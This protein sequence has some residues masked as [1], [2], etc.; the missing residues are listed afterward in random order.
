MAA[1]SIRGLCAALTVIAALGAP[2][3]AALADGVAAFMY[4]RFGEDR[5]PSTSVRLEQFDAHLEWLAREQ[6]Q[7]WPLER[8]VAHLRE[9]KP[10]P[11]R[12][13][14]LTVDDAFESVYREAWPRLKRRGWPMTVFVSTHDVD[15]GL[16]AFMTWDQMRE[17]RDGG[18]TFA[19]H[20]LQHHSLVERLP[21][22][23]QAEW[24]GRI[25]GEIMQA[26]ARLN[27]ELGET[28]RLFAYPYGEFDEPL[29]DLVRELGYTA[30]G[31]HSGAIGRHSDPRALPRFPM[32]E[33]YAAMPEFTTKARSR[34]LAVLK[35][36]P[37][38][39]RVK[40]GPPPRLE[41]QLDTTGILVDRLAC[42]VTGQDPAEIEWL[43]RDAG[44]VAVTA[45]EALGAGRARYNCT[46]P[47]KDG[48]WH[49]YSHPWIVES[50]G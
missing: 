3:S 10:F 8:V 35:A 19:N 44:R 1:R 31:Q 42:Y 9:G 13:V 16:P 17:M 22:E 50:G 28:P 12:V 36:Q 43:D 30:F 18:V 6:Y 21:R 4:H 49:W 40:A 14:S 20:A 34:A 32:A 45:R 48:R 26:Q 46:A 47:G 24:R 39:P 38:N 15:R 37:W 25:R 33:A 7:V 41:M 27:K 23:S 5:Y 11:D 2:A 29:A